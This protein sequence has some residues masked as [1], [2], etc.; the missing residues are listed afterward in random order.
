MKRSVRNGLAI[1]GM[2]G[3]IFFLGDAVASADQGNTTDQGST[4]TTTSAPA[5]DGG[6]A[7]G[8]VGGNSSGSTNSS[9]SDTTAGATGG[10]GGDN[11]AA[12]NTGA[13]GPGPEIIIVA[14]DKEEAAV[15][16]ALT[17]TPPP[18]PPGGD[19]TTELNL[20]TGS[21]SL[22]QNSNGGPV[23]DSGNITKLP[24]PVTQKNTT[25][26]TNTQ[27]AT[28]VD[29]SKGPEHRGGYTP[30]HDC[31]EADSTAPAIQ[32]TDSN[33]CGPQH[34][35]DEP[36]KSPTLQGTDG[37]ECRPEHD[38]G[39]TTGNVGGNTS[40]SSNES[41]TTVGTD[42]K[43]GDGGTNTANVNTGL[44]NVVLQCIAIGGGDAKCIYNITTGSVTV[45]QNANGGAVTNSGNI[46]SGTKEQGAAPAAPKAMAPHHAKAASS[47]AALSS[48]QPSSGQLAFT[49]SDVSL[50][51]TVGLLA[52]GA[53]A[54]LTLLGR[55]P[56]LAA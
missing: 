41:T 25:T 3:G 22:T 55:R 28:S 11:G 16:A 50:P 43:G 45:I 19:T 14:D 17:P 38:H 37:N 47:P 51:L 4:G 2:A 35:C 40:N 34:E 8:N 23:T 36:D 13:Q 5:P 6:G 9:T 56:V 20:T 29:N 7:A 44:Q 48:A 15:R 21:V 31:E 1:A 52:L 54:G 39:G 42:V 24:D 18:P 32:G 53:G 27:S 26:Q 33:N 49:G 46:G 10:K 12:A 30:R